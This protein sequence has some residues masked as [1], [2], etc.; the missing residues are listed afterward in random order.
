MAQFEEL[1]VWQRACRLSVQ[2]YQ[3]LKD[4]TNFPYRDQVTR[5]GLS[6][7]SNIAEGFERNSKPELIRFLAIAKGSCGELRTQLYI[8]VEANLI[9]RSIGLE[10]KAEALEISKMIAGLIKYQKSLS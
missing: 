1:E 5:S 6:V 3:L 2:L 10:Y 4:S 7:A 8:G 9:D